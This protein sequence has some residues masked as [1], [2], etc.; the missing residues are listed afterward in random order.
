[1]LNHIKEQMFDIMFGKE[2][3]IVINN[4]TT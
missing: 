3:F 1:M 2:I 4:G